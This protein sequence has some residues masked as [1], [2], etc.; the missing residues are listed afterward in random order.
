MA[1]SD[2]DVLGL[3]NA[4]VDVLA[5]ADDALLAELGLAKGSMTLI[6]ADQVEA[7]YARMGPGVETSGGSCANTMAA[8][9]SLGGRA[10]F[11]GRVHDDQL[12]QV[13]G[14]D[15]RATGV[16]FRSAPSRGGLPTARC[17]IF[18]T[19]DAQRTMATFLGACV[20]LGPDDVDE[21]L[22]RAADI[23]YLEGY[24]WDKD[25]AKEACL[26]AAEIA[27]KADRR[28]CLTLSDSFCVERWRREFRSLIADHVDILVANESEITSLYEGIS[29]DEAIAEVRRHCNIAALTRGPVGCVVVDREQSESV[30]QEPIAR[31]LDTTGAG[32]AFAAGFL[33][34][35]SKRLPLAS[36]GQLGNLA[37]GRVITQFGA[38]PLEPLEPLVTMVEADADAA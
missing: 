30:P 22:V 13:F 36:C 5:H 12:G 27:R 11:I 15:M 3:G 33:Y 32:D 7:L 20:E 2:F 25:D 14:H 21:T 17:L 16:T 24:L 19:P 31:V 23:T 10:A 1:T 28:V 9:A 34:G 29:F 4:V 8:L 37:A 35:I 18:V 26:K 6:E 38:R